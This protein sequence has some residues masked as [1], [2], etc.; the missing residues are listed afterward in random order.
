MLRRLSALSADEKRREEV[1]VTF[2]REKTWSINAFQD[3]DVLSIVVVEKISD[4]KSTGISTKAP[5]TFL[6][7]SFH[8]SV[9]QNF[10]VNTETLEQPHGHTHVMNAYGSSCVARRFVVR[11]KCPEPL[12]CSHSA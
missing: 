3:I 2:K 4:A 11:A 10:N 5:L 12:P 8:A 9:T 6:P 7:G 1:E